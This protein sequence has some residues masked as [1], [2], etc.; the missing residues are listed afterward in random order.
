MHSLKRMKR[1]NGEDAVSPV[2]GVML[3]L[4]VT[5]IIAAVVSGFAGGLMTDQKKSP[6]IAMDIQI[7]NTGV[8]GSSVFQANVISISDPIPS[9]D[10]K[11]VTSWT[12]S[13]GGTGGANVTKGTNVYGWSG[14][15]FS[16]AGSGMGTAPW[17]YGPGV[18]ASNSGKPNNAEQQFGNYTILGGTTMIA[19]PAGQGGGFITSAGSS[20]YGISSLWQ[21]SGWDYLANTNVDG[22][23]AVLGQNWESLRAGNIV[24]VKLI[25]IPSGATIFN[26]DVVVG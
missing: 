18:V 22:M 5:I 14:G 4:V 20:G 16:P 15:G 3:M 23:Q 24:N 6:T 25:Y 19:Y 2:V 10:L 7:K 1:K 11:L 13:S 17:G 21:Y 26:K 8:Y 12:N 9:K